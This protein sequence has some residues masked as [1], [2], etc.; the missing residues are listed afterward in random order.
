MGRNVWMCF[1]NSLDIDSIKSIRDPCPVSTVLT[2]IVLILWL[3]SLQYQLFKTFCRLKIGLILRKLWARMC[4]CVLTVVSTVLTNI[5][6]NALH[7]L[8]FISTVS[9]NKIPYTIY[10]SIDLILCIDHLNMPFNVN[11]VTMITVSGFLTI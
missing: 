7:A 9:T 2:Y 6:F 11:K 1:I 4:G 10:N 3:K 8:I 5:A